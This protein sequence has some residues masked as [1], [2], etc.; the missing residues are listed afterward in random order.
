MACLLRC[1]KEAMATYHPVESA[2][3]TT[4]IFYGTDENSQL[5]GCIS[6]AYRRALKS[7]IVKFKH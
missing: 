7:R 3:D 6:L 2:V 5:S 1:L 4:D